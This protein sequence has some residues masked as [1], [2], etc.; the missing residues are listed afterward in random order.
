[1]SRPGG[2]ITIKSIMKRSRSS[3][4]SLRKRLYGSFVLLIAYVMLVVVG[5]I[6]LN[7]TLRIRFGR[8]LDRN[9]EYAEMLRLQ[10]E[11]SV[12]FREALRISEP[13]EVPRYFA[14]DE[15]MVRFLEQGTDFQPS[16]QE[17]RTLLR[18]IRNMTEY[19]SQNASRLLAQPAL[20]PQDYGEISFLSLLYRQ[21]NQTTQE[22]AAIEYRANM[23][24]FAEAFRRS[25]RQESIALIVLGLLVV[26]FGG[27]AIRSI[28]HVLKSTESLILSTASFD[29]G[30]IERDE[31]TATG[32]AEL[33]ALGTAFARMK[34]E[35]HHYI[36]ELQEKSQLE[37]RLQKEHLENEQKD[38]LLKQAQLDFL[39]SQINPHFLFN[40]L[41]IIGK[42][43]VLQN[44][45]KSLELIE[46]ISLIMRYT[47]E[48]SD[49]LVP[50]REELEIIHAYLFIQ[51]A[52]FSSRLSYRIDSPVNVDSVHVP[53]VILQP[54][55]ENAIKYGLELQGSEL[56]VEVILREIGSDVII[57]VRDNG[58]GVGRGGDAPL[59][60]M[61]IGLNNL[62]RRLQ[63]RF[64]RDDLITYGPREDVSE[65]G[66]DVRILLPGAVD[67]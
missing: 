22:L 3:S 20:A 24:R 53:P 31:Y 47:L 66:T 25:E 50:L 48:H 57:T 8:M 54:L 42:S 35:I 52:R 56:F 2:T 33:D 6:F 34:R 9:Q 21:M 15:Q 38:R 16:T 4:L 51:Q 55:V 17:G 40:T 64:G 39:R 29:N 23:E 63:L 44:A 46:A 58:P 62:R 14:V 32:Y 10:G 11:L 18:M 36:E 61:G 28:N 30:T 13:T 65:S 1:M 5:S 59:P 60:G 45:E 26:V 37:V 7:Y 41:N 67:S 19:Q 12:S 27:I 49:A 43:A